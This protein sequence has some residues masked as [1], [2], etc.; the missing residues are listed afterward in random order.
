M[1]I[2]TVA[3]IAVIATAAT[4]ASQH[5]HSAANERGAKV[6]GF[7]QQKTV[8]HFHLYTDGGAIDVGV[9]DPADRTNLDAI[10]S[11]LPH[12]AAMFGQ[13]NFEAPMLVHETNVPGTLDMAR[14]KER[15]TF[16]Y[17]MTP[18]GGRVDIT[19]EDREALAAV[20]AFLRF[21]I[22]DHKTGD[23]TEVKKRHDAR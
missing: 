5:Q 22:D 8:H 2:A 13:G 21:Q 16:I 7:D 4:A 1:R 15:I 18:K 10:R 23:S 11:H 9:R 12:I 6:M 19:T 14:L 3:V 17:R 20:H